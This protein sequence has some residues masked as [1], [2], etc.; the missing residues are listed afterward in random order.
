[1]PR[2]R[3]EERAAVLISGGLDSA[4]LL[5]EYA[6]KFQEVHPLYVR[7]GHVW[8]SVELAILVRFLAALEKPSLRPLQVLDVPVG[9]L[10]LDHWSV[11]GEGMPKVH[12][13]DE[14]VY[15]PGRNALLLGKGMLWC[16]LREVGSL[17][18]GI[19]KGNPFPDATPEFFRTF[20][21]A[22]NLAVDGSVRL[23]APYAE[24]DKTEVLRRG[25]AL[26]LPLELTLSCLNPSDMMHCG[27]CNKC[28][29]RQLAFARAVL[30]DP[31]EYR[32][33]TP[34]PTD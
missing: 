21:K 9:D 18:L 12:D 22:V 23:Q 27:D 24:L 17:A 30:D 8:E 3:I 32:K 14:T 31:T 1:M 34:L 4:I 11:S 5:G 25:H 19:L 26:G 2:P 7:S 28:T 16:H 33:F 6:Q 15:L 20:N 10:L 13:P 29:E